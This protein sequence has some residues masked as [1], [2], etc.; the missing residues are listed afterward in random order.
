[1]RKNVELWLYCIDVLGFING[2]DA[3]ANKRPTGQIQVRES[4]PAPPFC[5]AWG[6][7][8]VDKLSQI[9]QWVAMAPLTL[10]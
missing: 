10:S 6:V 5:Q 7:Q 9:A 2:T 8:Q 3:I 4:P 1:M